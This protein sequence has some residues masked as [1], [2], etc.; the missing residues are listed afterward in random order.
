MIKLI[1]G[2]GMWLVLVGVGIG[3]AGAFA[4][5]RLMKTLLY[6]VSATDPL[7]FIAIPFL[8]S[9][10]ALMACCIPARRAAKDRPD[11]RI[12]G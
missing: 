12:A 9:L 6:E 11:G 1:I 7:T 2:Q 8:L 10:V 5:T 3:L 4:M